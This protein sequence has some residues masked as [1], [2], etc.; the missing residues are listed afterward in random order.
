MKL[1]DNWRDAAKLKMY[2]MQVLAVIAALQL[3]W[4]QLPPELVAQFPEHFVNYATLA[5]TV[6][7][8]V[9]RVL[10]QFMDTES[11][12]SDAPDTIPA[13]KEP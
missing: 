8:G 2:V 9:A 6:L 10:K 12:P 3:V 5:L 11:P 1:I 7:A 4:T 13:P